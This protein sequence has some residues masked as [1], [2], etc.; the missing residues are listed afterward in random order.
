MKKIK[1][2]FALVLICVLAIHSNYVY[3]FI[4]NN[5]SNNI[6]RINNNTDI[7]ENKLLNA[8]NDDNEYSDILIE[9]DEKDNVGIKEE[10][11]KEAEREL[12]KVALDQN[13]VFQENSNPIIRVLLDDRYIDYN[14]DYGY[15]FFENNRTQV[16]LRLTMERFGAEVG[17]DSQDNMATVYKDRTLV[18]IPFGEPYILVNDVRVDNDAES[19]VIDDRTYIP[20]RIVLEAFG[21]EVI[22]DQDNFY[23]IINSQPRENLLSS[24]PS[25]YDYRSVGRTTPVKNQGNLGTCWAF[26]TL[27]AFETA[28]MPEERWSFSENHLSIQHGF[29][30]GQNDGGEYNMSLAYLSR[31]SGPIRES[32]DA[33]GDGVSPTNI[34]AVKH[35]QE[36]VMLPSKNYKEIK[37]AIYL[38]GG[39]QTSVYSPVTAREN[40]SSYYNEATSS[41]YYFGEE[42]SNH[43]VVL[44]GWDDDYAKENFLVTPDGDGAFIAKNSWGTDFGEEGY[45]YISYYDNNVG[46]NNIVYTR[47]DEPDNY[48]NI[49]QTDWLGWIGNLG[50]NDETAYFANVYETEQDEA[51]RAVSFYATGDH[52]NYEVFYVPEF[53][54]K[55]SLRDKRFLT[56]G[57]LKFAGYYTIDFN[58]ELV[59]EENTQFAVVV[60]IVTPGASYPVAIEFDSGGHTSTVVI[61]DGE[62]YISYDG[63]HWENTESS[64]ESNISLKAFTDNI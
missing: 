13:V 58:E 43:D 4:T 15:P 38:H 44:I 29:D 48:D 16:P 54:D 17:W 61:D 22:W 21:A 11:A 9:E 2:I 34:P 1:K 10:Q 24:L 14:E 37:K 53:E 51:L 60:K 27:G 18:K 46:I 42:K 5:S 6:K 39:V 62:G 3:S 63:Y 20:I 7:V 23:V 47:I 55:N 32:D 35:L 40:N 45:Y 26:A 57:D 49:Y 41:L 36:A 64:Q 52:S 19:L 12:A 31:W 25:L 33:Y 30:L 56:S 8:Q 50:Y 28:L 59:I